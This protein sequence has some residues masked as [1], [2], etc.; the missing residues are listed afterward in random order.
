MIS[1]DE[2]FDGAPLLRDDVALDTGHGAVVEAVLHAT[3]LGVFSAFVNGAAVSDEVLSPGWTS[4][5]WR[6]RYRSYPV[7]ELIQSIKSG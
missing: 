5:E 4:Y 3:A 2:D 7:T 6:L 1:A